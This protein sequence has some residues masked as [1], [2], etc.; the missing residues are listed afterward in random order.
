MVQF[1]ALHFVV[2]T[3]HGCRNL[4]YRPESI[5]YVPDFKEKF[6]FSYDAILQGKYEKDGD[7]NEDFVLLRIADLEINKVGLERVTLKDIKMRKDVCLPGE[8]KDLF[9]RGFLYELDTNAIDYDSQSISMQAY[10]T[11]GVEYIHKSIWEGCFFVKF[12]SPKPNC[13]SGHP[14]G[15]SGSP[16]FGLKHDGT[17]GLFGMI[18]EHD[19]LSDE[20]LV[21]SVEV[22]NSAIRNN[23]DEV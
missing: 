1:G 14:N 20:F 18:I 15:M 19:L 4:N 2:S 22:I 6:A 8:V 5:L 7:K 12:K 3:L 11:N 17:T 16:V 13:I 23:W 21:L 10:T 9:T